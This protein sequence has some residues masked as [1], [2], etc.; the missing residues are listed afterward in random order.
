[1]EVLFNFFLIYM[2]DFLFLYT[3]VKN[4]LR[5]VVYA[6]QRVQT[7][8]KANAFLDMV[9]AKRLAKRKEIG[10]PDKFADYFEKK[11]AAEAKKRAKEG[12]P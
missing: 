7:E 4:L 10:M 12:V 9:L 5:Y 11:E 2:I 8:G 3:L 6:K 1:M